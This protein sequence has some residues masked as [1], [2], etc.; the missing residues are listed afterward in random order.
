M[1]Y[2]LN[3]RAPWDISNDDSE[4]ALYYRAIKKVCRNCHAKLPIDSDKC[5]KCHNTDLRIKHKLR[6]GFGNAGNKVREINLKKLKL[7][8]N[9]YKY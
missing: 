1:S 8:L 3:Y 4:I 2:L 7:N 9:K 6:Y 5:R